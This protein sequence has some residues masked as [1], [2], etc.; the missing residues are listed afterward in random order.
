MDIAGRRRLG[1]IHVTVGVEPEV[2]DLP[3]LFAIEA[4]DTR[5]DS[6]GDGMISAQ[7]HRQEA[8]AERFL[9][10]GGDVFAGFRNLLQILGALFTIGHFFGLFYLDVADVLDLMAELLDARLQSGDA[11]RGGTHVDTPAALAEVH[12]DADD[13]YFLGH[14]L[15]TS[16]S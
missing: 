13:A 6:G 3:F 12:G 15:V 5:G 8:F 11:Q 2:A 16:D 7:D 4:G 10:G 14:S 9:R 1:C